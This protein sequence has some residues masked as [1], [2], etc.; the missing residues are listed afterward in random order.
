MIDDFGHLEAGKHY[1]TCQM[2]CYIEPSGKVLQETVKKS[3]GTLKNVL[4]G[5]WKNHLS[6]TVYHRLTLTKQINSRRAL[7]HGEGVGEFLQWP[8]DKRMK[9]SFPLRKASSAVISSSFK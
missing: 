3:A 7:P 2:V 6:V 5:D 8:T 4:A 9:T 1:L